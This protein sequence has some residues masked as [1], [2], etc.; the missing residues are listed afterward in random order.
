MESKKSFLHKVFG[1]GG[2]F[3]IGI[4]AY[5]VY[6]TFSIAPKIIYLSGKKMSNPVDTATEVFQDNRNSDLTAI[7]AH[8]ENKSTHYDDQAS[9]KEETQTDMNDSDDS[10]FSEDEHEAKQQ[11]YDLNIEYLEDLALLDELVEKSDQPPS[12]RWQ[13][14]WVSYDDWKRRPDSFSIEPDEDGTYGFFPDRKSSQAFNYNEEKDEFVWGRDFYG[15]IITHKAKF[16]N[17]N[18]L[19]VMKISGRKVALDLYKK[20]GY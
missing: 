5:W 10:Y 15:K 20:D 16:I 12:K 17:D 9:I 2:I 6:N 14:S 4:V 1:I 7:P 8:S 19:A 3:I 13:G 11:V 18:L